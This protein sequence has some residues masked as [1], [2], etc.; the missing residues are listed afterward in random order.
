MEHTKVALTPGEMVNQLF[1]RPHPH[2]SNAGGGLSPFGCRLHLFWTHRSEVL[3]GLRH[4][5]AR[6]RQLLYGHVLLPVG[7]VR[8]AISRAQGAA[9]LRARSPASAWPA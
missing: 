7:A 8:L 9:D 3:A 4:G 2:V 5:R 1:A 6:H